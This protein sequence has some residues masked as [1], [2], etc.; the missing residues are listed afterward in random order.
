[1]N[2][3]IYFIQKNDNTQAPILSAHIT[4]SFFSSPD[5]KLHL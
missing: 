4:S 1:M 3:V 2:V 5:D